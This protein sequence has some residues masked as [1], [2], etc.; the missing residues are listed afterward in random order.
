MTATPIASGSA[1]STTIS[2]AIAAES[3]LPLIRLS[4]HPTPMASGISAAA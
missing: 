4:A 2:A 1:M 3:A